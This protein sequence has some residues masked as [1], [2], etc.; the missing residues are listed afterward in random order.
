[1][2]TRERV[3]LLLRL[4]ADI[5]AQEDTRGYTP[6]HNA[7]TGQKKANI[8]LLVEMGARTDIQVRVHVVSVRAPVRFRCLI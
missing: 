7:A 1:M 3:D 2:C 8:A 5:N 6:L 4:G